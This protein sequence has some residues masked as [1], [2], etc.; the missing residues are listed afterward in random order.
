[1]QQQH[2]KPRLLIIGGSGNVGSAT[3][4]RLCQTHSH[5]F[6]IFCAAP[7]APQKMSEH[8]LPPNVHKIQLDANNQSELDQAMGNCDLCFIIPP[9]EQ[10]RDNICIKEIESA[11]RKNVKHVL[12]FSFTRVE[13]THFD[14]QFVKM[15]NA[16]KASGLQWTI[17]RGSLFAENLFRYAPGV[18]KE[19]K[20]LLNLPLN[21]PFPVMSVED[22]GQACATVIAA[23][24]EWK[25]REINLTPSTPYSV[26]DLHRDLEAVLK[27]KV[28]FVQVPSQ[29]H[30]QYLE[31]E[32][33]M[34]PWLAQG[35]SELF[36]KMS[37]GAQIHLTN[38]FQAITGRN[39]TP[40]P[41]FLEKHKQNFE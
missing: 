35:V 11:I 29:Q 16:L 17:I 9:S 28:E 27:K 40:V 18:K 15:E 19:G 5:Q 39:T 34:K 3:I 30:Q 24:D 21:V 12:L 22:V 32:M 41:T 31:R 13:N 20:L 25:G 33:Q 8:P 4:K 6:E 23:H 26:A 38:D 36:D 10:D 14:Q 7:D 37:A 2:Q 1:M